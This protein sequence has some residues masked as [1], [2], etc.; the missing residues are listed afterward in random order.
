VVNHNDIPVPTK[1]SAGHDDLGQTER[2]SV[3][4]LAD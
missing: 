3:P 1:G 4:K 2:P